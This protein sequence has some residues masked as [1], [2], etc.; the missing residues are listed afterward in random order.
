[1]GHLKSFSAQGGR[2]SNK[3][4]LKIQMS[5]GLPGRDVESSI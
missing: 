4:V 3:N 2:D 1:M 5:E